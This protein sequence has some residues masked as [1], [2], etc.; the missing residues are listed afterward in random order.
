MITEIEDENDDPWFHEMK[1]ISLRKET[2]LQS[3]LEIAAENQL[4]LQQMIAEQRQL[5]ILQEATQASVAKL[6]AD[7]AEATKKLL[8]ISGTLEVLVLESRQA[9]LNKETEGV[10]FNPSALLS[11][12]RTN[13]SEENST[14]M[15][16]INETLQTL[17]N[18]SNDGVVGNK[19]FVKR[20]Y[21]LSSKTQI[22][23]WLDLLKSELRTHN[24]V[25]F[26]EKNNFPNLSSEEI[27]NNKQI[28]RDI[29]TNRLEPIYHKRVL[30]IVEPIDLIE[31]L[32][33]MK[34]IESNI[35][36]TSIRERLYCLRR[37]PKETAIEFI[38]RFETLTNEYDKGHK[39]RM[40]DEERASIFHHCLGETCPELNAA[41]IVASRT[42]SDLG[43]EE[44]KNS[45]LQIEASKS[46]RNEK[47]PRV[48]AASVP[49]IEEIVCYR[50]TKVGHYAS[51]C[52]LVPQNL[53]F[54]Y[55]CNEI[56][57]HNSKNCP[58]QCQNS[59]SR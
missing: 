2:L 33:E 25:E 32:K 44:M 13:E 26:I 59:A 52:P 31:K 7:Q 56:K 45:F 40:S 28:V 51:S 43:Y 8:K 16:E 55:S 57:R 42:G 24:L 48:N 6:Q 49:P 41:C 5:R 19:I 50:C 58:N 11:S 12:T 47:T 3:Q 1:E 30:N 9:Q 18:K 20:N 15:R 10:S 36:A 21:S 38:D 53:W 17:L 46:K 37:S 23:L 35:T 14:Q 39:E 29:I 54:C 27:K 34:R 4:L 22:D